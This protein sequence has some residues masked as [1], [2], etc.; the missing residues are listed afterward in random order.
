[1]TNVSDKKN[2]DYVVRIGDDKDVG[3]YPGRP[4]PL[5]SFRS[6]SQ[7]PSHV[8]KMSEFARIENSPIVSVVAYCIA[9][10]SMTVV[11]KYLVSGSDWNMNFLYLA[12]QVRTARV[13]SPLYFFL[14]CVYDSFLTCLSS[15]WSVLSASAACGSWASSSSISSRGIMQ[16]DVCLLSNGTTL[17]TSPSPL[18]ASTTL[19]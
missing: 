18:P 13:F 8:N 15:L 5:R 6:N 1:M 11:N 17:T 19:F 7:P 12:I 9:S 10:I 16:E 14:L 2:E 4:N 3:D